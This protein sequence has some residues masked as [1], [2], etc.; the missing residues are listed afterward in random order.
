MHKPNPQT[1]HQKALAATRTLLLA[2]REHQLR[3]LVMLMLF[4]N[5]L[6]LLSVHVA[7]QSSHCEH[8]MTLCL[9]LL[10]ITYPTALGLQF[11]RDLVMSK[12]FVILKHSTIRLFMISLHDWS[13]GPTPLKRQ[14]ND[15]CPS[16]RY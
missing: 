8:T 13:S 15:E 3:D 16:C 4:E 14:Q 10:R 5:Q 7:G 12:P 1:K 6:R 9:S 11:S 2:Q